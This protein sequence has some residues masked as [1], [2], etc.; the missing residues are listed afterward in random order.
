MFAEKKVKCKLIETN[1]YL[2]VAKCTAKNTNKAKKL[3]CCLLKCQQKDCFE[4]TE[5]TYNVCQSSIYLS[6]YALR[7]QF[8]ELVGVFWLSF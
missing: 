8:E 4:N 3:Y 7:K 6:L 2:D 1:I 5:P